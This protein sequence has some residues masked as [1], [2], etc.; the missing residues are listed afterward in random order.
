[1]IRQTIWGFKLL[2]IFQ[3]FSYWRT[4]KPKIISF[5]FFFFPLTKES[6]WVF[7][8][9][10]NASR[11]LLDIRKKNSLNL[12]DRLIQRMILQ[13]EHV[14]SKA[15]SCA[16]TKWHTYNHQTSWAA[17]SHDTWERPCP[18]PQH[19][20]LQSIAV[21]PGAAQ[22]VYCRWLCL[23]LQKGMGLWCSSMDQGYL[24]RKHAAQPQARDLVFS[25]PEEHLSSHLVMWVFMVSGSQR[26]W[27]EGAGLILSF[28]QFRGVGAQ[29]VCSRSRGHEGSPQQLSITVGESK[30]APSPTAGLCLQRNFQLSKTAGFQSASSEANLFSPR[31]QTPCLEGFLL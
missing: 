18:V 23:A 9:T 26:W 15:F 5:F 29:E 16:H 12:S 1:M 21:T 13:R 11:F 4:C 25:P 14:L 20:L 17:L 3:N 7:A 22:A 8:R 27:G 6:D 19:T 30:T 2:N 28:L 24:L 10:K 31:S